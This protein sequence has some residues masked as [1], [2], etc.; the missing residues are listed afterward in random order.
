MKIGYISHSNVGV[1]NEEERTKKFNAYIEETRR[2]VEGI[3]LLEE[4]N[5]DQM[6]VLANHVENQ[7]TLAEIVPHIQLLITDGYA[8]LFVQLFGFHQAASEKW[9]RGD[10]AEN[11]SINQ[12]NDKLFHHRES[13][14]CSR[15]L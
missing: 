7:R 9:R 11:C 1:I 13:G 15:A 5:E 4:T 12:H 10:S 8:N 14:I 6:Y 2:C 3:K